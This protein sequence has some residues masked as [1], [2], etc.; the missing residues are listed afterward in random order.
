MDI[1]TLVATLIEQAPYL[2]LLALVTIYN[3]KTFNN[4]QDN[5]KTQ[6][7]THLESQ[8]RTYDS[9]NAKFEKRYDDIINRQNKEIEELKKESQ[10][11]KEEVKALINDAKNYHIMHRNN[12]VVKDSIDRK[13][14]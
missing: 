14:I 2:G 9:F 4:Y 11:L 3:H 10:F 1:T 12:I 6:N 7:K 8:E 5:L 13:D